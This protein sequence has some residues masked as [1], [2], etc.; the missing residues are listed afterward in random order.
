MWFGINLLFGKLDGCL[1]FYIVVRNYSLDINK[2]CNHRRNLKVSD[3]FMD[4]T[5]A[6]KVKTHYLTI[7]I[8]KISQM[9]SK[10]EF[11]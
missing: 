10:M 11:M 3:Y 8:F 7:D 1:Y 9:N 6:F 4:T 5:D 2:V